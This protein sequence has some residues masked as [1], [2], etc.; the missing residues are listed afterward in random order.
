MEQFSE[1]H[2]KL[3][4]SKEWLAKSGT[5]NSTSTPY[6][7]KFWSSTIDISCLVV[8][9]D[10]KSVWAEV[11]SSNQFARRWRAC[12][13][14]EA[15]HS[16]PGDEE[17]EWRINTLKTLANAHTLGGVTDITFEV[18]DSRYSDLAFELECDSFKW[19]WESCSVGHK[20]G[21]EIISQHL[22]LP[23]ISMNHLAFTSSDA[24]GETSESELEKAID[25]IGRTARRTIDTHI[26]NVISKPRLATTLRRMTAMFNFLPELPSVLSTVETPNLEPP[27]PPLPKQTNA[28]VPSPRRPVSPAALSQH[29][30]LDNRTSLSPPPPSRK[31]PKVE[32]R[33]KTPPPP[34]AD[35]GSETESEHDEEYDA[36]K[37]KALEA[38]SNAR[39]PERASPP[40]PSVSRSRSPG[41]STKATSTR[42][43]SSDTD[44]SPL[45]PP[46]KK[47][48]VAVASSDSDDSNEENSRRPAPTKTGPSLAGAKRGTRQ[49][50]KRGGKRF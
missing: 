34:P 3:L 49:P 22:V 48:K 39:E 43:A 15:D 37:G 25:K 11:L 28:R 12:N 31:S 10:T 2:S 42:K 27:V 4:L 1:E 35:S 40:A 18:V 17:E 50:I 45:P 21:S 6:L 36:G 14:L 26:K 16:I 20:L 33:A 24:V 30:N 19:R 46:A 9:T 32:H 5:R 23:L 44:S 29:A 47:K 13:G 41:P 8:I 38:P 7:F